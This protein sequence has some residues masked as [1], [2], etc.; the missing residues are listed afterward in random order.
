MRKFKQI[1][2]HEGQAKETQ[3]KPSNAI[4][5]AKT[6]SGIDT[7]SAKQSD[8]MFIISKPFVVL[9]DLDEHA[10]EKQPFETMIHNNQ[11]ASSST[12][13][14]KHHS[15]QPHH[16]NMS[17]HQTIYTTNTQQNFCIIP[18]GNMHTDTSKTTQVHTAN[19]PLTPNIIHQTTDGL[20]D[21]FFRLRVIL[22]LSN[23]FIILMSWGFEPMISRNTV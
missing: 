1:I 22:Y 3:K 13:F 17:S 6:P 9:H 7:T 14:S 5:F 18:P 20:I 10:T 12:Y 16:E 23:T 8:D 11:N 4:S 15:D 21:H 19:N 2:N